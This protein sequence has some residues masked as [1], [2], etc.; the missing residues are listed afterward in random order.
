MSAIPITGIVEKQDGTPWPN[1]AGTFRLSGFT[2]LG[3]AVVP[4]GDVLRWMTNASGQLR[5]YGSDPTALIQ[6]LPNEGDTAGTSWVMSFSNGPERSFVLSATG[7]SPADIAVLLEAG[8]A[9]GAPNYQTIKNYVDTEAIAPALAAAAAADNAYIDAEQAAAEAYDASASASAAAA[10]ATSAAGSATTAA[11]SATSAA[12]AATTAA[13]AANSAATSATNAA[14]AATAATANELQ[15]RGAHSMVTAYV[16]NDVVL[17]L[18]KLWRCILAHTGSLPSALVKWVVLIGPPPFALKALIRSGRATVS[19]NVLPPGV[20]VDNPFTLD[21]VVVRVG[22]A[23]VGS[24]L[25]VVVKKNGSTVATV[26]VLTTATT[27][28]SGTGLGVAFAKDDIITWDIT[29]I[30]ST[31]PGSDVIVSHR[32]L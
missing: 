4:G 18:D 7:P 29:A 14:A 15:F 23:P 17:Y 3:G 25:T 24:S 8:I 27:G 12:A 20:M 21:E 28:T 11:G 22:T 10:S 6:L 13:G 32:A 26:S 2:I 30:G 9:P 19:T 5:A 31:T 1:T 16:V